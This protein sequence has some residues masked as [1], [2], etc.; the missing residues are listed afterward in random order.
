MST[1]KIIKK[2]ANNIYINRLQG[3]VIQTYYMKIQGIMLENIQLIY[4][5]N[6]IML[7]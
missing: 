4:Q 2:M 1:N 7:N 5:Q 6:N 3:L